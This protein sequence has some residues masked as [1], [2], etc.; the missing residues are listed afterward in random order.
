MHVCAEILPDLVLAD[1]GHLVELRHAGCAAQL[2][3][4]LSQGCDDLFLGHDLFPCSVLKTVETPG[5]VTLEAGSGEQ[6]GERPKML[7]H[8]TEAEAGVTVKLGRARRA[9]ELSG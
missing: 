3:C 6:A 9:A 7:L 2:R 8:F 1:S 4:T 5:D